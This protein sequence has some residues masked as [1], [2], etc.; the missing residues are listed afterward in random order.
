MLLGSTYSS[1]ESLAEKAEEEYESRQKLLSTEVLN[2]TESIKMKE[3][4][5]NQLQKS[6]EQYN[7]MRLFYQKRLNYL[8]KLM[9]AK[10][11]ERDSLADE[12]KKNLSTNS[13]IELKLQ[14]EL[15]LKDEELRKLKKKHQEVNRLTDIQSKYSDK[16]VNLDE[17]I[18]SMKRQRVELTKLLQQEKRSHLIAINEKAREIEKLKKDLNKRS[19]EIKKLS[20]DKERA[21]YRFKD[22]LR[23]GAILRKKAN[24]LQKLGP[25]ENITAITKA[26]KLA[27]S[28]ITNV[29]NK[30]FTPEQ[31]KTKNWLDK[32]LSDITAKEKS[33]SILQ[34][35]YEQQLLLLEKKKNLE[36][37]RDSI[38]NMNENNIDM[39]SSKSK[40]N[41]LEE[42]NSLMEALD[43]QLSAKVEDI[44]NIQFNLMDSSGFKADICTLDQLLKNAKSLN[45]AIEIIKVLFDMLVKSRVTSSNQNDKIK[46]IEFNLKDKEA[47]LQECKTE[48][49]FLNRNKE[50]ELTKLTTSYEAKLF[51]LIESSSIDPEYNVNK[52]KNEANEMISMD[53][54]N[55]YQKLTDERISFLKTENDRL[56]KFVAD[57]KNSLFF[58]D[59]Q[60][61]Q[62]SN[63][64]SEK[65]D[66]IKFIE[67]ECS[68][69]KEIADELRS[70]M[71]AVTGTSSKSALKNL[72]SSQTRERLQ[73]DDV[74]E[75][76]DDE[77]GD[78]NNDDDDDDDIYNNEAMKIEFISL[79]E[80][81][82]KTGEVTIEKTTS[83]PVVFERLTNP[84]NFTGS[85]KNVFNNQQNIIK[86]KE[87]YT[88]N[89]INLSKV[90]RRE[91]NSESNL[92]D[93]DNQLF[94]PNTTE[95]L[96]L[97]SYTTASPEL[98]SISKDFENAILPDSPVLVNTF[99]PH[100]S[101]SRTKITLFNAP[102][103]NSS[104]TNNGTNVFSRLLNPS[105]Y[106]GIHKYRGLQE[107]SDEPHLLPANLKSVS[108]AQGS[109]L[110][111]RNSFNNNPNH[112]PN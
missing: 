68:V 35:K 106:T 103:E 30:F 10:Q 112:N 44:D 45:E 3:E 11:L 75:N 17:E 1:T 28:R 57:L 36:L 31:L 40:A 37:K 7:S 79:A 92:L 95:N 47:E 12:I 76:D 63:S 100:F 42:I 101:S 27:L 16:L 78:N 87:K 56:N 2:L 53:H 91:S 69:F 88:Q 62:L 43:S 51:N 71:L 64:V 19:H 90:K 111:A 14:E 85:Q 20:E 22:A 18:S 72:L 9:E 66:Y 55:A 15:F 94:V 38:E 46:H 54:F 89:L 49:L 61:L 52:N 81:I 24:L 107:N 73:F 67:E 97:N 102:N 84:S 99:P 80:E 25:S 29:N 8:S 86:K 48:L 70:G 6:Q 104:Q 32:R 5:V 23:E 96:I 65:N 21:E 13:S 105:S 26:R 77:D 33:L 34:Q 108:M 93:R 58:K 74:N 109:P 83:R 82:Q 4:L 59:S 98:P 110:R 60:Y 41:Y 50:I 39:E